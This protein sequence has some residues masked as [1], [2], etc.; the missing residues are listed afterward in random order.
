MLGSGET[1]A[2]RRE[3]ELLRGRPYEAL[4]VLRGALGELWADKA[5][6]FGLTVI[7]VMV[8]AAVFAPLLAPH[9]PNAQSLTDRLLPPFHSWTHPLGTDGLGHDELSQLLY[10]ARDSLTVGVSVV[11]FAGTV[12]IVLGLLAGYRGG[13]L[14]SIVMR[15]VDTQVAF[16]GLLLALII[17]VVVSPSLL[18]VIVV[19]ALNGWMVYARVTHGV[20]LSA[21]EKPYVEAAELVGCKSRRVVFRH[22]LPNLAS[23]LLTLAVLEFARVVL[24]EAALAFLGLGIPPPQVSWGQMVASG[25]DYLFIAWWASTWPG[26]AISLLVL[27][28]NLFASWLRVYADPQQRER[29]F[30]RSSSEAQVAG[31]T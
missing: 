7:V 12:G 24:A 29:R 14:E 26:L 10:G 21:K 22:I 4:R 20:V 3:Q 28:V 25:H 11:A 27:G 18:S 23:P 6:F 19:L 1:I 13:R 9:D 2:A 30:A 15:A 5:G 31:A 8:T 16:P 17:L